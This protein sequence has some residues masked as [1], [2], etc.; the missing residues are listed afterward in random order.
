[1]KQGDKALRRGDYLTAE[2]GFR[3]AAVLEPKSSSAASGLSYALL[4]LGD[5]TAGVAWAERA[6]A[7]APR[8][9]GARLALGDAL[10]KAGDKQ[11]AAREWRESALL[12][13]GNREA[14]KRLRVAGLP[15]T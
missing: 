13:P 4:Q 2:R 8:S 3:R 6:V 15:P 10:A 14:Q 9:S 5:T 12:D 7:L 1:M 11:G